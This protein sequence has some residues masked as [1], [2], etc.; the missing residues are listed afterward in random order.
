[1]IRTILF[2]TRQSVQSHHDIWN[3]IPLSDTAQTIA[4]QPSRP[5][6]HHAA[7]DH[8]RDTLGAFKLQELGLLK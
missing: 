7:N 1:V 5:K 4:D 8:T 6:N 2:I 3:L